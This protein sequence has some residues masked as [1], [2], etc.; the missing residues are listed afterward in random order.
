MAADAPPGP[1]PGVV[2]PPPLIYLGFLLLGWGI[3]RMFLDLDLG[4]ATEVRRPLALALVVAGL[5]LDGW[6]G[7]LFRRHRTAVEP[8]KPASALLLEGPYRFSRNPIYLGFAV[9][10]AGFAVGMDS[11]VA[12]VL[13]APCLV[14]VDR[15]VIRREETYLAAR[16][17]ESYSAYRRSVRRWI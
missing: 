7:G 15:F 16:F 6:A 5:V 17:G 4:L 11:P 8:W 9:A 10:Y 13:L 14:L 12:L 1:H 3:E 2:F